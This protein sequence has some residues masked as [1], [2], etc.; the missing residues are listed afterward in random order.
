MDGCLLWMLCCQVQVSATS[1]SLLQR[2]PTDCVASLCVIWNLVF[3]T[4]LLLSAAMSLCCSYNDMVW[5][6]VNLMATSEV[7]FQPIV[8]GRHNAS[9][10][11]PNLCVYLLVLTGIWLW[12]WQLFAL[13]KPT[14]PY[15]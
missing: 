7:F 2:S 11:S 4:P 12:P 6:Q 5:C 3:V 13:G 1:W 10:A 8:K 9:N 15:L 14:L